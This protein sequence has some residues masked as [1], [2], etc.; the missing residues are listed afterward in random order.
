MGE[1]LTTEHVYISTANLPL[2]V[3]TECGT[4]SD[5]ERTQLMECLEGLI[6]AGTRHALVLDLSEADPLP[7]AHR[8]YV[9]D[10][11]QMHRAA[12]TAAWSA[13]AIVASAPDPSSSNNVA[14]WI[15]ASP[16]PCR[17][18]ATLAGAQDW[19]RGTLPA[20]PSNS[21]PGGARNSA[22]DTGRGSR[23]SQQVGSLPR[24][25]RDSRVQG[26]TPSGGVRSLRPSAP[27]AQTGSRP[28]APLRTS[29]L[30]WFRR[31][32]G[33]AVLASILA[34][35]GLLLL[36]PPREGTLSALEARAFEQ[37]KAELALRVYRQTR[38]H[39]DHLRDGQGTAPGDRLSFEVD[40]PAVGY[41]ILFGRNSNG[42]SYPLWPSAASANAGQVRA[43]K[44][45][46][47]PGAFKLASGTGPQT[48][49]VAYC[50]RHF[51]T[52]DCTRAVGGSE[53]KCPTD[54]VTASLALNQQP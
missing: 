2:V 37:R 13:L 27:S 32:R 33:L 8:A 30:P 53:P 43:G 1:S 17:V 47:P 5:S 23:A 51:T 36:G 42:S 38:D 12:I 39:V 54:C 14:F 44:K 9:A 22:A 52:D 4:L 29:P 49:Y 50:P 21:L 25:A 35:V 16:V 18:F 28:A 31:P 7:D 11:M 46:R 40:V 45:L 26:P 34:V 19:A 48:L 3:V 15:G 20:A 10:V 6:T 41:L 24:Q